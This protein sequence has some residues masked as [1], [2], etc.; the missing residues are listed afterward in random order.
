MSPPLWLRQSHVVVQGQVV[1]PAV[2][3]DNPEKQN[4][5]RI[6]HHRNIVNL[7]EFSGFHIGF[8]QRQRQQNFDVDIKI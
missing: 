3:A 1:S 6:V 7:L 2:C 5:L 4:L 8:C